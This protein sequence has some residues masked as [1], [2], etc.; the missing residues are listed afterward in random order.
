MSIEVE[1]RDEHGSSLRQL[2]D[3]ALHR[4]DV[5]RAPEE[6]VCLRFVDPYGDTVFNL[7]QVPVLMAEL[8]YA[9]AAAA[10][11]A[12]RARLER[13]LEFLSNAPDDVHV[14]ACFVGD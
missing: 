1:W 13:V 12:A 7:L 3:A 2:Q 14:Y 4:Q 10:D 5:E 9:V 8:A 6:S 11:D